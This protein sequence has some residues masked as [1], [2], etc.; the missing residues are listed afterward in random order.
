MD[1]QSSSEAADERRLGLGRLRGLVILLDERLTLDQIRAVDALIDTLN[2]G[3]ALERL[4]DL[5]TESDTPVPNDL[6]RDFERLALQ[7]GNGERVMRGLRLCPPGDD[8]K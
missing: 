3:V 8:D 5:L 7:L 4:V 2:F 6:R 1:G